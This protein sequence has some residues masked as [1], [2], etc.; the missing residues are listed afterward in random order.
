MITTVFLDPPVLRLPRPATKE[1]GEGRGEGIPCHS[2]AKRASS[3]RP[4]PPA[5]PGGEGEDTSESALPGSRRVC[6]HVRG[7]Q[8]IAHPASGGLQMSAERRNPRSKVPPP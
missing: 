3:P 4:S 6:F 8:W 7:A 5:A 1:R 2:E